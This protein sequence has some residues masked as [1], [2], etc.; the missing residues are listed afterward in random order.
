MVDIHSRKSVTTL[1]VCLL[2]MAYWEYTPQ[3][4]EYWRQVYENVCGLLHE[5]YSKA[6]PVKPLNCPTN[7]KNTYLIQSDID[8]AIGLVIGTFA[9]STTVQGS[10]Y[11]VK[12]V[13]ELAKLSRMARDY[14]EDAEQVMH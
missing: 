6:D 7:T 1:G 4:L 2:C 11:W 12:V 10:K 5:S 14:A 3:G 8:A 9:W 13:D